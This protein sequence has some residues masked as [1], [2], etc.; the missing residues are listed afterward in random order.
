MTKVQKRIQR[1]PG[2]TIGEMDILFK[3]VNDVKNLFV[4][5]QKNIICVSSKGNIIA[6]NFKDI[7]LKRNLITL[8]NIDSPSQ[9]KI[10]CK[11]VDGH[12]QTSS[13]VYMSFVKDDQNLFIS[14]NSLWNTLYDLQR[15]PHTSIIF[16][17][18][19][20]SG[21]TFYCNEKVYFYRDGLVKVSDPFK[22][23]SFPLTKML[24]GEAIAIF[25]LNDVLCV[26]TESKLYFFQFINSRT[27]KLINS[28]SVSCYDSRIIGF[29]KE[30][31]FAV[32]EMYPHEEID[33]C[34]ALLLCIRGS[35]RFSMER[36]FRRS[37]CVLWH[38][39]GKRLVLLLRDANNKYFF[40][41]LSIIAK[42]VIT[43]QFEVN[44]ISCPDNIAH[45]PNL[46][47]V[48]GNSVWIY[49]NDGSIFHG[50]IPQ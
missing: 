19:S 28:I 46:L 24:D 32:V 21:A 36:Y 47:V 41:T 37:T 7:S 50:Q 20:L 25:K 4:K 22:K 10:V 8:Y 15:L 1:K 31:A 2:I 43:E 17:L 30:D 23:K 18:L 34:F 14:I 48:N 38:F 40:G 26:L 6:V 3:K 12:Q 44:G 45:F 5:G 39:D 16:D 29:Q 49:E 13:E 42:N 33:N 27:T 11:I 9:P 35:K